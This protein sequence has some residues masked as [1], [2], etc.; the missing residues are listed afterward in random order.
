[1][2]AVADHAEIRDQ[3][4]KRVVSDF[5][6]RRRN[7]GDQRGLARIRKAHQADVG[8]ELELEAQFPLLA[9]G[10]MLKVR[11]DTIGG[12]GEM[13]VASSTFA[14]LCNRCRLTVRDQV[15]QGL[16]R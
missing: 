1:M 12:S 5:G 13:I 7:G 11:G 8:E 3:G 16:S 4:C 2:L 6:T 15:S 9:F 10:P 14:P